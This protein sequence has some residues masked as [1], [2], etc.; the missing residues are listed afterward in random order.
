MKTAD[1]RL[2]A[3]QEESSKGSSNNTKCQIF[4]ADA[5][6]PDTWSSEI[7]DSVRSLPSR[8]WLV[9]VDALNDFPSRKELLAHARQELGA[10]VA[11][12]EHLR[13]DPP[14]TLDSLKLWGSFRLLDT[15]LSHVLT[16][17]QYLDL[18][19]ECGYKEENISF[20][21]YTE[22]VYAPYSRFISQQGRRW[23]EMGGSK[24]DYMEFSLVGFVSDWW[25]RSGLVQAYMIVAR[26]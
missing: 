2:K 1:S 15:P 11:L 9:G 24:W 19:V 18:L 12:T 23:Q 3:V 22:H 7:Q 4:E 17:Q 16:K 5:A 10:S 13:V 21:P 8:P 25:A 14:S 20:I 26:P 6:R